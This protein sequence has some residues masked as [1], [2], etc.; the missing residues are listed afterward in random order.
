MFCS[1]RKF[2]N[3]K[4]LLTSD[5]IYTKIKA[6]TW[7]KRNC[8]NDEMRN[9]KFTICKLYAF[10][11]YNFLNKDGHES[12]NVR[13]IA[14]TCTHFAHTR[15]KQD[16]DKFI[17]LCRVFVCVCVWHVKFMNTMA[18]INLTLKI[19]S[20]AAP[21]LDHE[22]DIFISARTKKTR[23][24]T[25]PP[26]PFTF[27]G[28]QY[29]RHQALLLL[30]QPLQVGRLQDLGV[31]LGDGTLL[32]FL[33]LLL[34][35]IVLALHHHHLLLLSYTRGTKIIRPRRYSSLHCRK[36]TCGRP[37]VCVCVCDC[38]CGFAR[39]GGRGC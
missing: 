16:G 13:C 26:P 39:G 10:I 11:I 3:L 1:S 2:L 23:R 34:G 14:D 31:H 28:N 12:H 22:S 35:H 7:A 30:V 38:H 6:Q 25:V 4:C 8:A 15:H 33:L 18:S 5:S 20:S 32:L 36:F 21:A 9:D 24:R 29:A 17:K 27:S 37:S 19:E